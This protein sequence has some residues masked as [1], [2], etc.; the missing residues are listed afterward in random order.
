M[1][2][3]PRL[4]AIKP[5]RKYGHSFCVVMPREVR[6]AL[7]AEVN[8]QISFRKVGRYVFIAVVRACSVLPVSAAELKEAR[9]A[10]EG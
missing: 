2:D 4:L 6:E 3:T 10:L 8:D 9:A 7:G 5:V 1:K